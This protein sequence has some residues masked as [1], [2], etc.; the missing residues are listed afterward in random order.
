VVVVWPAPGADVWSA[1]RNALA[2]S[3][4]FT[5]FLADAA[6]F[7]TIRLQSFSPHRNMLCSAL[8]EAENAPKVLQTCCKTAIDFRG[9]GDRERDMLGI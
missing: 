2:V 6:R 4:V 1:S 7:M 8:L 9:A 5:R 3:H